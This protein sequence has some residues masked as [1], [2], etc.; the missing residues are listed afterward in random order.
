MFRVRTGSR[1]HFGLIGLDAGAPRR[2]G[3][4]GL[5][6]ER[7]GLCVSAAPAAEWSASGPL[8]ER[9][10]IYARR[11]AESVGITRPQSLTVEEAPPEH[12][13]LGT[14]TQLGL[15]VAR[16]LAGAW[17]L[18]LPVCELAR[19]VGR[20]LRSALGIHGF[21]HGGF[22]VDGGKRDEDSVAPLLVRT[23]FPEE[24]RVVLATPVLA[25]GLH[26]AAE[27]RA[28]AQLAAS[29]T[30]TDLL[31]R[32]VLLGLL[33]A[34]AE[35]DLPAFG[36]ALYEFNRRVGEAFAAAQGGAY[37]GPVVTG[38]VE[39]FRR[40]G[41]S[42]VGQSSWGPTVFA[43]VADEERGRDLALRL[44]REF[45]ADRVGV[46]VTAARNRGATVE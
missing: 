19:H 8:A 18:E 9:A 10:L 22:L 29:P 44:T 36:E 15:A 20:G 13:G 4:V 34:L 46:V 16:V 26:G 40:Q 24:L 39:W 35:R 5:I 3:G 7:P 38:L 41:V 42:G 17:G 43:V 14:G 32:L 11:V 31:C 28:F 21:E 1:L 6:V 12:V 2:F 27:Q 37:A 30:R 45:G 25:P 23:A 33:P